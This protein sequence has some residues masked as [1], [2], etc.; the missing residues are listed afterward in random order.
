M[1]SLM[2]SITYNIDLIYYIATIKLLVLN[3]LT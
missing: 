3:A 1:I 2:L